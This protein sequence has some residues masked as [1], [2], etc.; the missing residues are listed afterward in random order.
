MPASRNVRVA[1][2]PPA[3]RVAEPRQDLV[4]PHRAHLARRPGQRDDTPPSGR[5]T[6]QPGAVPFAFGS[7]SADGMS[8]ACL[9][10]ISGNGM[11]RRD[12]SPRSQASRSGSTAGVSPA[13]AAIAS[14]VR[15]SGV[16]PRPPVEMTRSARSR[17]VREARR[18]DVEV[19]GQGL[20]P[21]DRDPE[22]GQAPGELAGV[23]VAGLADRQLAADAQ[24]LRGISGR[25]PAIGGA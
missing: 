2:S 21:G 23:R 13:T 3:P 9:R 18:D 8:Q 25:D 15:S 5:L 20:D 7:A 10:L 17:A 24:E 16:G 19:V 14:R 11:P 12:Q 22:P 6:H 4:V 1:T